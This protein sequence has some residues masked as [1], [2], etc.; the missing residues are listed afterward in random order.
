LIDLH[1]H[2]TASDGSLTPT[3]II[4]LARR[5]GLEAVAITDHD[6]VA[7]VCDALEAGIPPGLGF[8]TG[9]E[10]SA[11]R[12][13]GLPG[14][15][16]L[17]ILGYGITPDHPSLQ[18][19]LAA[20]QAA[21][22]DRNPEILRRLARLGMPLTMEDVWA[23]A[24]GGGQIGRPHIAA[25]LV[26]KGYAGSIDEAFDGFLAVGKAAYV[27]KYRLPCGQAIGLIRAA[28]GAA[29]LAHPGLLKLTTTQAYESLVTAL[30]DQGLEGIEVF[31]P[32]HDADQTA[33]YADLARR[34][35]LLMSGGT[36]FHGTAKPGIRLGRG[37]GSFRVGLDI[38]HGLCA[39]LNPS[40][41]PARP[42]P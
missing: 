37:Q 7:G 38:Y 25:A 26:A 10:I 24:G 33:F 4:A 32:E 8:L 3:E 11:A 21:R 36:D 19:Q 31:Y 41:H 18:Q 12:P 23:A 20:L 28:G 34:S 30:A 1:V 35:G 13:A 39:R 40:N 27:D 5:E 17:H 9:I 16:S 2:T 22:R 15:G 6:T 42:C 14:N 29:F